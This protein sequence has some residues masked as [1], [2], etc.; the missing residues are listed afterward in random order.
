MLPA[1]ASRPSRICADDCPAPSGR[2]NGTT[3]D[4]T[5]DEVAADEELCIEAGTESEAATAHRNAMCAACGR[6][7]DA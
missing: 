1:R 2:G 7:P 5:D 4:M 3:S 6:V